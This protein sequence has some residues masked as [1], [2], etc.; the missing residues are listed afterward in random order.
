MVHWLGLHT[1]IAKVSGSIP[2]HK[3]YGETKINFQT[4]YFFLANRSVPNKIH[5]SQMKTSL[6]EISP[7]VLLGLYTYGKI[8]HGW[9]HLRTIWQPYSVQAFIFCVLKFQFKY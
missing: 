1:L 8:N 2:A 6:G 4:M 9:G 3:L 5:H 7:I